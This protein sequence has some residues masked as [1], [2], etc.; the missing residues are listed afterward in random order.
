M[1]SGDFALLLSNYYLDQSHAGL[2]LSRTFIVHSI[3][4]TCIV[5]R[6]TS[7]DGGDGLGKWTTLVFSSSNMVLGDGLLSMWMVRSG[8]RRILMFFFA[9][10]TGSLLDSRAYKRL[11]L[12]LLKNYIRS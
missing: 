10:K 2:D 9:G 5:C 1:V 8:R 4:L 3:G 12:N 11:A 7:F 6:A